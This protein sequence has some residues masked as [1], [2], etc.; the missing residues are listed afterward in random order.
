MSISVL[1]FS[2]WFNFSINVDLFILISINNPWYQLLN[3]QEV[4]TVPTF[5]KET[6]M[7][8]EM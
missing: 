6:E 4:V 8:Q 7:Q 2:Y 3:R 5:L 1:A